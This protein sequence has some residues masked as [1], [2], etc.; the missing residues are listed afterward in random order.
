MKS[1]AQIEESDQ[2]SSFRHDEDED[3]LAALTEPKLPKPRQ[4]F[5][6]AVV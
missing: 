3:L 1:E 2:P 4:E 5:R 6:S